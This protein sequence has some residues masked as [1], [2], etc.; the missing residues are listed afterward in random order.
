MKRKFL[1]AFLVVS[2]VLSGLFSTGLVSLGAAD[3]DAVI[4]D[5]NRDGKVTSTDYQL[6]KKIFAGNSFSAEIRDNADVNNDGKVT[7][8]DYLLVKNIFMG[9][10]VQIT[11]KALAPQSAPKDDG[12]PFAYKVSTTITDNMVLQRNQYLNIFG[13]ADKV[14][15]VIYVELMGETRYAVVDSNGEWCVQM[16]AHPAST[17][18]VELQVYTKAQG[19]ENG[20][21]FTNILLGDVWLVSG[22]SNMQ[23]TLSGT[24]VNN[25]SFERKISEKDNIR[26]FTQWFW[27]C[28]NYWEDD[29]P[30]DANGKYIPRSPKTP[31]KDVPTGC[32]W[33][34]N[35]VANAKA[36]S[37]VGY[38]FAKQVANHTDVP[39]GLIQMSAG[40]A[41]L[42]DFMPP[43]QYIAWKHLIGNSQFYP[44]DIYNSL[45]APFSKTQITGM[46]WYQGESDMCDYMLYGDNLKDFVG[47]MRNLYGENMAFYSV[48]LTSHND[49]Y[50]MWPELADMRFAQ[51]DTVKRIDNYYLVCSMDYGSGYYDSDFAHPTNKKHIGDRLA[52]LALAKIYDYRNYSVSDYGSPYMY[53]SAVKDSY[54]YLY[55]N[56]VGEGLKTA[57]GATYVK[58]F[59]NYHTGAA[60]PA[61]VESA[62]CV[63]VRIGSIKKI[64]IAYGNSSMADKSTCTLRNSNGIGALAF[65]I[66]IGE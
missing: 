40:G 8:T 27:N 4:G 66:D 2:L 38:Y 7:S 30:K 41:A 6:I 35:N 12:Q 36:F 14:G 54:V 61:T 62:N 17:A 22:Q 29:F 15:G 9:I 25:V 26:L 24:L 1:A 55:F 23:V 39:I 56:N 57:D 18:P 11:P 21:H 52:Y 51:F 16:S 28:T 53:T 47:M 49:V 46:L 32:S 13:T 5:V 42:C 10:P 45:M 44:S 64:T 50:Q 20:Y 33:Q 37:A 31:Q 63:K 48:Q 58:G 65:K 43:D 19:A 34:V 60:L 59:T 3:T